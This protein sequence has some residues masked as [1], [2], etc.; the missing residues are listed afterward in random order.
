MVVRTGHTSLLVR[1]AFRQPL[2]ELELGAI[3]ASL[4]KPTQAVFQ[5]YCGIQ[6]SAWSF[7]STIPAWEPVLESWDLIVKVDANSTGKVRPSPV[8]FQLPS[9][10]GLSFLA[11]FLRNLS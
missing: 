11:H 9:S 4:R 1:D 2:A 7:N 6:V 8:I 3:E 10:T 5:F